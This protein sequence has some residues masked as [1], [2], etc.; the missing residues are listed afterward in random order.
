MCRFVHLVVLLSLTHLLSYGQSLDSTFSN[1]GIVNMFFDKPVTG[2][3]DVFVAVE[4][5]SDLKLIA[6]GNQFITI[7]YHR[8]GKVDSSFG[9]NGRLK[10]QDIYDIYGGPSNLL[11]QPDGKFILTGTSEL[12]SSTSKNDFTAIRFNKDGNVDSTFGMHGIVVLPLSPYHDWC[13]GS[14][15]QKDGKV[16]LCGSIY[17]GDSLAIVRLNVNGTVDSSF[18]NNGLVTA[19]YG[20]YDTELVSIVVRDNGKIVAGGDISDSPIKFIITQYLSNGEIDTTFGNKGVTITNGTR[21]AHD[22]ALQK[23]GKAVIVGR[24][25]F[26]GGI[27]ARYNVDGTLDNTF[28][29][30]G[31]VF[32]TSALGTVGTEQVEVEGTGGIFLSG[33]IYIGTYEDMYLIK[34]NSD[35]SIDNSFSQGGIVTRISDYWERTH[36]MILQHD[37]KIVTVGGVRPDKSSN[38]YVLMRYNRFPVSVSEFDKAKLHIYPNPISEAITIKSNKVISQIRL[39]NMSGSLLKMFN[40]SSNSTSIQL[41]DLPA[42]T[43][44]LHVSDG[45]GHTYIKRIMKQ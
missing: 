37:G 12:Q 43:Y 4:Q 2:G 16:L 45:E 22:M 10:P 7:R 8:D 19:S 17:H 39:T 6:T 31:I 29:S 25:V 33:H 26:T 24:D 20:V 41:K 11:I 13:E 21:I 18:G 27:V 42:A 5:Q 9:T 23:D 15:L 44:L 40:I 30:G 3:A 28:G 34:L 1:D 32:I 38:Q 35:G 14:A 36:G